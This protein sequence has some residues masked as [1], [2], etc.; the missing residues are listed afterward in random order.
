MASAI[1]SCRTLEN[2][3][4]ENQN[5]ASFDRFADG[6]MH[7]VYRSSLS[8]A[9]V[10]M[11]NDFTFCGFICLANDTDWSVAWSQNARADMDQRDHANQAGSKMKHLYKKSELTFSLVLVGLY[12]ALFSIAD[13]LSRSIGIEKILTAPLSV[14]FVAVLYVWIHKN[15]LLKK[16]GLCAFDG[17]AK[18]YFYFIPLFVIGSCNLWN[19]VQLNCSPMETALYVLSMLCVG[20]IEELIFR[21]FLFKAMAKDGIKSAIIVSSI[22]FGLGHIINLVNGAELL[23]T[24]LQI[25]YATAIGFLFTMLFHKGKCLW[26]CIITHS[27]VN[28][29]SVIGVEGTTTEKII[30]AVIL[31]AVSLGYIALIYKNKKE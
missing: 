15:G 13:N 2:F 29:L 9:F 21:G 3:S 23:P 4:G 7:W 14:L 16:Y 5:A 18:D 8:N 30:S 25:I 27:V 11:V 19:G 12:V 31:T 28:S 24:F 10:A 26:P 1:P 22:T 20:F 17:K 6:F